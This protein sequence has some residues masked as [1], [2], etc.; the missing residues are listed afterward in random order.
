MKK[1]IE[2]EI[3]IVNKANN[4]LI[5]LHGNIDLLAYPKN[6]DEI[7]F[8]NFFS[9]SYYYE[10]IHS[11]L[12]RKKVT[13]VLFRPLPVTDVSPLMVVM[14]DIIATDNDQFQNLIHYFKGDFGFKEVST[15]SL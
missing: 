14:E 6:G 5:F 4:T 2:V 12:R 3:K 1:I 13:N 11:I 15:K 9:K 8:Q 7:L 10:K